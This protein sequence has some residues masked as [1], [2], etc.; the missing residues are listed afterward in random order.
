MSLSLWQQMVT[1][2]TLRTLIFFAFWEAE[3]STVSGNSYLLQTQ[4]LGIQADYK[5]NFAL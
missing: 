1:R 2:S 5:I 4:V 3:V